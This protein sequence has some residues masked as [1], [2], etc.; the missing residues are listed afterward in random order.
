MLRTL[1]LVPVFVLM[2]TGDAQ[3][4]DRRFTVT[5]FDKVR[6][7]GPYAVTMRTGL[8]PSA[9]AAGD[10]RALDRLSI[11]VQGTTLIVKMDRSGWTGWPG[12]QPHGGAAISLTTPSL[13]SAAL[14]GSG[15]V[16]IDRMAASDV[17]I[18]ASGSGAISIGRIEADRLRLSLS[19]AGKVAMAGKV[20]QARMTVLGSGAV[21]A[22]SL[23]VDDA[24]VMTAGSGDIA[25]TARRRATVKAEGSGSVR[26]AGKPACAVTNTGQGTILCGE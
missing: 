13:A 26:V 9:R 24:D 23:I 25:F 1:L 4:A 22:E 21:E 18:M 11:S 3:A 2:F 15:S 17:N 8:G 20:A 7:E 6:I 12:E 5:S 19:G 10:Q 16:S 14:N